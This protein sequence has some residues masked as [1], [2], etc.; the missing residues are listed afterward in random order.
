MFWHMTRFIERPDGIFTGWI[1]V[2][3]TSVLPFALMASF[4]A[5]VFLEGFSWIVFGH[6]V[7]VTSVFS[8]VLGVLWRAGL[9]AYSS[10]SS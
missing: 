7:L 10:A 4:P 9:R 8:V 2:V 1:R 6:L 5:R 3:L